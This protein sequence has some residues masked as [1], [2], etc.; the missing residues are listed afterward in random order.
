MTSP[1]PSS[2]APRPEP[3][4]E[5]APRYADRVYRSGSALLGGAVLLGLAG[6]IGID[7]LVRGT[8]R[9]PWLALA[10]LLLV[11]PLVVAFTFRPA[12]FAGED[13]LRVRNPF[14][15]ITLPWGT[16]EG[17]RASY[18]SEIFAGG[19]KFQLWAIPVSLRARKRSARRSARNA[20][21]DDTGRASA[22]VTGPDRAPG[23]E[24]VTELSELAERHARR[25]TAQGEPEVRW[26]YEVLAP[27]AV[28]A[29]LLL[30]LALIG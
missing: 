19:R 6:W 29:V 11:V 28:G 22:A 2:S 26:A 10:G 23:D 4:P 16:V 30:V 15:T 17:V 27:S 1:D 8:G 24:A 20:A 21:A 13:R 18:S 9:T 7:A 12:V 5:H 14:R 3:G 25:E